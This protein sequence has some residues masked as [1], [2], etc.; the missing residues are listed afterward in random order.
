MYVALYV[1]YIKQNILLRSSHTPGCSVL[2]WLLVLLHCL[3]VSKCF[4]MCVSILLTIF[5]T[6][7]SVVLSVDM[8]TVLKPMASMKMR[9]NIVVR[10]QDKRRLLD[11]SKL[12]APKHLPGHHNLSFTWLLED[13]ELSS[14]ARFVICGREVKSSSLFTLSLTQLHCVVNKACLH[15]ISQFPILHSLW[16]H[17]RLSATHNYFL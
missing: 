7:L 13:P 1:C 6:I 15:W 3:Q 11:E 16:K 9:W 5:M 4:W 12:L 8:E 14:I 17:I 10:T 2:R